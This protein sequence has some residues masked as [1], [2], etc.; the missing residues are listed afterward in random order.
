MAIGTVQGL[1]LCELDE[2]KM[3]KKLLDMK[4]RLLELTKMQICM[5]G[6]MMVI[7]TNVIMVQIHSYFSDNNN[8]LNG[9]YKWFKSARMKMRLQI[10][11]SSKFIN[12]LT[13]LPFYLLISSEHLCSFESI[14]KCF[15]LC[16]LF[17]LLFI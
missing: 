3:K 12:E 2:L 4:D 17:F 13:R 6:D 15:L 7:D 16:V 11:H 10:M 8:K 1:Y 5:M 14:G 9:F